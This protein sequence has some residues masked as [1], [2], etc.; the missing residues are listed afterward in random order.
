MYIKGTEAWDG[1]IDYFILSGME[2]LDEI[3]QGK[4][5]FIIIKHA[6]RVRR[7]PS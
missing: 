6:R 4:T 3:Y 5:S 7:E 2:N 1:F